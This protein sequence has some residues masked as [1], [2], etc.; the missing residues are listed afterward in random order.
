MKNKS[1]LRNLKDI[2]VYI[3]ND[4]TE[5]ERKIQKLIRERAAQ[6]RKN[7][8]KVFLGYNKITI[9]GIRWTWDQRKMQLQKEDTREERISPKNC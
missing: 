3:E 5:E 1:K 9:N 4:L 8:N 2:K 7:G 6:E